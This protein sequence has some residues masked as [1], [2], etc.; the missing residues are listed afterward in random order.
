MACPYEGALFFV[1]NNFLGSVPP[2][3][4]ISAAGKSRAGR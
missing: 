1:L 3:F 4:E 2:F